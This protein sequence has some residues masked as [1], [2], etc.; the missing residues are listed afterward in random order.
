MAKEKND[1]SKI[2]NKYVASILKALEDMLIDSA[3][4]ELYDYIIMLERKDGKDA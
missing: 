1:Y 2:R 3:L 4:K